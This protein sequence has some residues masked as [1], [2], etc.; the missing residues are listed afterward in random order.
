M[1]LLFTSVIAISLI[2]SSQV[3][4]AQLKVKEHTWVATTP[5]SN[6]PDSLKDNDAIM[7]HQQHDIKNNLDL[8]AGKIYNIES[9]RYRVKIF[10]Q[11]GLDE[12]SVYS[13]NKSKKSSITKL[14]ART[15][16]SDGRIVDL[17][18]TEIKVLDIKEDDDNNR[19]ENIR[20]SIPGVEIG[21]EIEIIYAIERDGFINGRDIHMYNSIPTLKS[22]FSYTTD[23][24]VVTDFR[25]YND[26]PDPEIKKAMNDAVFTWTLT[27]LPGLGEQFA[28]NFTESLPFLRFAVRNI[29]VNG[30]ALEG[31]AQWGI[32]NN[33]WTEIFD[34][35]TNIYTNGNFKDSYKGV[36][37]YGYM[38]NYKKLHPNLK[39]N[40][41]IENLVHLINDSLE[42]V[43]SSEEF[44]MK[45]GMYFIENKKIDEKNI[46]NLIVNY[47][48]ENNIKFYIVFARD[49]VDGKMDIAFA[50][51]DMITDV[52][53]AAQDSAGNLRFIYPSNV[54]RKYHIDEVPYRIAGTDAVLVSRKSAN[55]LKT[56]AIKVK[57]PT[58]DFQVNARVT[59]VNIKVDLAKGSGAY[60][61]K[62]SFTGS[63]S[64]RYRA[65]VLS[66]LKEKD[67]NKSFKENLEL[68]DMYKVDTFSVD[69]NENTYPYN[70]SFNHQGNVEIAFQKIDNT[71]YSI[72][73]IGLIDHYTLKSSEHERTLNYY[74]PF[75]YIDTYKV[76]LQFDKS[77]ELLENSLDQFWVFDNN[78]N[79]S[80]NVN[81][82]NDKVILIESKLDLRK[83]KLNPEEYKIHHGVNQ[84]INKTS[85][86]RILIKTM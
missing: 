18:S 24:S 45:S 6:I 58:N 46:H 73:L 19:Y 63:F 36:S 12:Y 20:V 84:S 56:D 65:D 57:I 2:I 55:A 9:I 83:D 13:I 11:A 48:S 35:Y 78:E 34:Y 17:K 70:F 47:L 32:L 71:T 62:H 60:K 33:D 77:I 74:C 22:V 42:I 5:T 43:E 4:Q 86:A 30:R 68:Y 72:P 16:K 10:T 59:M 29:I 80:I 21:D 49:K 44:T 76:Y 50:S 79:Y 75:K 38:K 31:M 61:I 67:R 23:N 7:V 25:M 37:F 8:S 51:G 27:N 40:E 15:I 66:S 28:S 14:D 26:L 64:T 85:Q 41:I 82:V 69:R 39:S 1:K 52:F 53:Y 81:K 3:S 54:Y